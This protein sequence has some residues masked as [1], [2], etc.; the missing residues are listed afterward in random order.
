MGRILGVAR[1]AVCT[2]Q[3][4]GMLSKA[5]LR[6]PSGKQIRTDTTVRK[7]VTWPINPDECIP[8]GNSVYKFLN[9]IHRKNILCK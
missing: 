9:D 7:V 3:M 1:S 4:K 8:R 2:I 6:L 5:T